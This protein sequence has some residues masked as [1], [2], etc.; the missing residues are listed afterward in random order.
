MNVLAKLFGSKKVAATEG[1]AL[2]VNQLLHSL[3]HYIDVYEESN[4]LRP[5]RILLKTNIHKSFTQAGVY[6]SRRFGNILMIPTT[7]IKGG[8]DWQAI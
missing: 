4:G 6:S 7:S 1:N 2:D 3:D 5:E 8:R